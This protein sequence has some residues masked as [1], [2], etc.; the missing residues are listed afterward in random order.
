MSFLPMVE[1]TCTEC[2]EKFQGLDGIPLTRCQEC[3]TK[4]LAVEE[5]EAREQPIRERQAATLASIPPRYLWARFDAPELRT[6]VKGA[7]T[8]LTEATLALHALSTVLEGTSGVGKT[9]LACAMLRART[10]RDQVQGMFVTAYAIAKARSEHRLGSGEAPLVERAIRARLLVLDEL[11]AEYAKN[12]A[13]Q[14]VIHDR[15]EQER[16]TI[17]T[18]GFKVQQAAAQYGEGIARRIF[19]GARLIVLGD[20]QGKLAMGGAS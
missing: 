4:T 9:S 1:K 18:T 17:Y 3:V 20:V 6:R 12:T 5:L 11:G 16:P 8:V 10:E 15:Y 7:S 19:E 14:E 2:G 13:V